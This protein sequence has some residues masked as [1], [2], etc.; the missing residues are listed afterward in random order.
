MALYRRKRIKDRHRGAPPPGF[1]RE[2][3]YV[4]NPSFDSSGNETEPVVDVTRE[5][6]NA[7][8]D[9]DVSKKTQ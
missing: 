4:P 8:P 6:G 9:D 5:P 7:T 1:P 3:P 2:H